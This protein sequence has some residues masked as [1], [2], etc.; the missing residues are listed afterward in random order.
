MN[1]IYLR[2]SILEERSNQ[3][4]GIRKS[5]EMREEKMSEKTEER[6]EAE[7]ILVG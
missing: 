3:L 5:I 2:G 1:D 4:K 7:E 6:I